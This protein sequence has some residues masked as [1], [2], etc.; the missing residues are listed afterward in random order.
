MAAQQRAAVAGAPQDHG[1]GAVRAAPAGR[2]RAAAPPA[3]EGAG[4]GGARRE[5]GGR[6]GG[7]AG[8]G[9]RGARGVRDE[10]EPA[11]AD[12]LLPRPDEPGRPWRVQGVPGGGGEDHGGRRAAH[13]VRLLPRPR[14]RRP[15]G[16]AP[17][18]GAPLRAASPGVRRRGGRQATR[19]RRRRGQQ[20]R[21]P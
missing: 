13:R 19:A 21:L 5:A 20:G 10:P 16:V 17:P 14:R 3:R 1:D 9:G 8:G 11:V 6:R 15:A 4:A 18:A 2:G 12:H 7:Q